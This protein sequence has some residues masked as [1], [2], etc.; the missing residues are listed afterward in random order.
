MILPTLWSV[1]KQTLAARNSSRT[2]MWNRRLTLS[3][4]VI[5]I[6]LLVPFCWCFGQT[7]WG[8][9]TLGFR[10][11][12][13]YF[14]PLF[15]WQCSE[16]AAGRIPLWNPH[17]NCG[18]PVVGDATSSV[19]YP[20]KLIFALP[21]EF[22]RRYNLYVSLHVL[23]AAATAYA[24]ARRFDASR[25]AAGLC[26]VSYAFGG[27]VLFQCCNVVF[28]VGAAWLPVA[29]WAADKMINT[30]SANW[31]VAL[32]SILA[33]MVLG[34]D[35]Q[36]AYHAVL[37][38]AIYVW[39]QP[40]ARQ[41]G[42]VRREP[43]R[44]PWTLLAIATVSG[45]L[46]SAVQVL[47]AMAWTRVSQRA[48]SEVPRNVYELG[49]R[50]MIGGATRVPLAWTAI[51]GG[52]LGEPLNGTHHAHIYNYS[53]GPWRFAELLWPN[54]YGRPVPQNHRW[55]SALPAESR[56]WTPSMY[57]GLLPL[58]L[59]LSGWSL[60]ASCHRRA[61]LS[62]CVLL[63]ACAS[64][65]SY[66]L[67]WALQELRVDLLGA[68]PEALLVG[69]PV[70]GLYWFMVTLL[71]GYVYFR[72]PA[73][74]LV[75]AALGISVLAAGG[76]DRL[77]REGGRT[78]CPRSIPVIVF[79]SLGAGGL[80]VLGRPAW[81]H[82]IE[83]APIDVIFGPLQETGAFRDLSCG[84]V[85]TGM[86]AL[87]CWF[88]LSRMAQLGPAAG[89][90]ALL[91][92]A[93][94]LILANGWMA[95]SISAQIWRKPPHVSQRLLAS[96]ADNSQRSVSRFFRAAP[97]YWA[98][99]HW[100]ESTS[101]TRLDEVVAWEHGS[102][103]PKHHLRAELSLVES[104]ATLRSRDLAALLRV[105]RD[106]GLVRPNGRLE[107]SRQL[108]DALSAEYLV[109]P[110]RMEVPWAQE[111]RTPDRPPLE[112]VKLCRNPSSY[113]KAWLVH[114]IEFLPRLGYHDP[115]ALEARSRA[116]LGAPTNP[117]DLRN[118]AVIE[119][120]ETVFRVAVSPVTA[121]DTEFCR[122][123]AYGP[124]EVELDVAL[125]APGCLVMN[126][127]YDSDWQVEVVG[128]QA[129]LESPTLERANRI[130]R[131]VQLP[132][133]EHRVIFRYRPKLFYGGAFCSIV[134]WLTLLVGCTFQV[135]LAHRQA[136][137]HSN[138]I[139][140]DSSHSP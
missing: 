81:A 18:M 82:W 11:A 132:A 85:Q 100:A 75:I 129:P 131:A 13:N 26:A 125:T 84:F 28:L 19:F 42:E 58:V 112:N 6:T 83:R 107:P 63:T 103:L 33:V 80:A 101:P 114:S 117:R 50:L 10:D 134:A 15:E 91:I 109:L 66:G 74:L 12:A 97:W 35:P 118:E 72:Y 87:V 92:T 68:D 57:A 136:G 67:G 23:L 139:K 39:L 98:P 37:L 53:V 119:G 140:S 64:L 60:R 110:A 47:P 102:I 127:T 16:W 30:R 104:A 52:L 65:G 1:R 20:A 62:W 41:D 9:R 133:G 99:P 4:L 21:I 120:D 108:L 5:L 123:V 96:R 137:E 31:A 34:G 138:H 88:L 93:L 49:E 128:G 25:I 89:Y 51:N 122:V 44:G 24:L 56:V 95:Q 61:W 116:V 86:V 55:I 105:S 22:V 46:L 2:H 59:G 71:P 113:P 111:I 124:Q 36:M 29:C 77:V 73:K 17:D 14:F 115:S 78:G 121:H 32:G 27:N 8:D 94:D 38:T 3:R 48:T 40:R 126:D 54:C 69:R 7:L 70:G 130:M 43:F 106:D 135:A 90:A 79:S 45:L 76:W